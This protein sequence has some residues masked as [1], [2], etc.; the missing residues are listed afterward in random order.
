MHIN[1][2]STQIPKKLALN[3]AL[4]I[5]VVSVISTYTTTYSSGAGTENRNKNIALASASLNNTIAEANG[6]RWSFNDCVG[7]A[8]IERGYTEA[9]AIVGDRYTKSIGGGVCQVATTIFNAVYDSGLPI[10]SR[11]NHDLHI[12]SYPEGRDAAI[13]YPYLDFI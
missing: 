4:D 12:A 9:G 13:S 8:T 11:H 10:I 5:G 6:G 2:S 3:E 7:D 1:I